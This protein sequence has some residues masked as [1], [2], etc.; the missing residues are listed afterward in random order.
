VALGQPERR[1]LREPPGVVEILI[2]CDAAVDGLAQQVRQR[3]LRVL[4]LARVNQVL[5]NEIPEVLMFVQFAHQKEA[6]IR[7]DARSSEID[8][9]GSVE[10][11]LEWPISFLTHWVRTSRAPSLR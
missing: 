2:A 10:R 7:G 11:E 5:G 6:A 1:I 8:L 4:P 9:E 3:E